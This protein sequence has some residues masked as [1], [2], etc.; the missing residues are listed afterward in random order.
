MGLILEHSALIT[1]ALGSSAVACYTDLRSHRIPIWLTGSALLAGLSVQTSSRG[2]AGILDAVS[3]LLICGFVFLVFYLAGGMGA[4][5]V[6]LV[7]VEGCFLGVHRSPTL[8]LGTA[9]AGGLFATFLALKKQRLSQT[10]RNVA[11]L[12]AHHRVLGLQPHAELNLD[13][14]TA[15]RLPYALAIASGVVVS[16]LIQPGVGVGQ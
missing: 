16:L 3:G 8:L 6:K 7:A 15:L 9:I 1:C 5:D 10:L 12:A 14:S 4:G 13:N 2:W 11:A